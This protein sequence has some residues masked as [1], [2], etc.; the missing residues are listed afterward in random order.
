MFSLFPRLRTAVRN[1][2]HSLPPFLP[3]IVFFRTASTVRL[4]SL[5]SLSVHVSLNSAICGR[6]PLILIR[7]FFL[8]RFAGKAFLFHI[9]WIVRLWNG[10]L[11]IFS[12]GRIILPYSPS[13][14]GF[15]VSRLRMQATCSPVQMLQRIT[16]SYFSGGYDG[17]LRFSFLKSI[18]FSSAEFR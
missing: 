2:H 4:F 16:G 3:V 18:F 17:I 14:P 7:L 9:K 13:F 11:P 12:A 6:L 5:I 10:A 1:L 8:T 15:P